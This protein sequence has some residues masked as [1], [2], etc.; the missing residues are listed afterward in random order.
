[1]NRHRDCWRELVLGAALVLAAH[2]GVS[3]ALAQRVPPKLDVPEVAKPDATRP[4]VAKPE[5]MRPEVAKPVQA[6][7]ELI[8][9]KK[10]PEALVKL[11]EAEG[12]ADRSP[13]ENYAI[14][15]TRG[16]AAAGS[17]D[18]ATSVK[19]FEAV[20]ATGKTPPA[21]Y[22][23]IVDALARTYFRMG[24][25]PKAAAW[26]ERSVKEGGS[27]PQ[28]NVLRVKALYLAG[29]YA[30]TATELR[31]MIDADE[32]AGTPPPLEQLQ[33]L[34]SSYVKLNDNAGYVAALEKLLAHYPKKEYWADAIRRV[35]TKPGFAEALLLDVLRLQAATGS[36]STAAQYMAMAQ[37]ALKAGFPAEARRI[38][39][40]GFA[41]GV[42]GAG[43]DAELQRRL[44]DTAAKQVAEDERMLVQNAKDAGAANDGTPL[45]N[46]GYAMVS[47]GQFDKGLALME[48]GLEKGVGSRPEAAKLH[49]A[50]AYLA[51][52]QKA[53]AIAMFKSVQG[54]DGTTDLARLWLI[55]A[56]RSS[57]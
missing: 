19:A 38:V 41:S 32:K 48:Q 30:T 57:S 36:L 47:A 6:A 50:I 22:P 27:D 7:E 29:D 46:V 39:D 51:A 45:V 21:D 49:L 42:L 26:A 17:D 18:M 13:Y 56:Q 11:R 34:A 24:D 15:R 25:Y 14:E 9:A 8:A 12:I 40:Q 54:S 33:L 3:V 55:H 20:L 10:F 52:G 44:R 5:A 43:P 37:L 35:E 4:E 28:M 2:G 23:R 16:V 53:K 1:M 31:P